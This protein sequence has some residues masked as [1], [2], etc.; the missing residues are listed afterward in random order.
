MSNLKPLA[1]QLYSLRDALQADFEGI[2][3]SVAAMGYV[4]VEPYAGMPCAASEAAALF[5]ELSLEVCNSH[6]PFPD[7]ANLDAVLADA[8][9]Y[10]LA[11]VAVAYLP[12]SEFAS[13]DA[14]KRTCERLNRASET[15]QK[16]ALQ[17]GYHNH[18]WEYKVLDGQATLDVML[19][20]LADEVFLEIDTY[21]AQVGGLDAVDVVKQAGA[22]APL[23]HLKDGSL[24]LEDNMTAVGAGKMDLPGI[25]A[26]TERTAD[27]HI[28]EI[29]R[30]DGDMLQAVH[31]SYR[32]LTSNQLA[33]GNV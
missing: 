30:C 7:A 21:W 1:L 20:E 23:I 15:L 17:L 4:G 8:E 19:A 2:L 28:V 10:G 16:S 24:R 33:R 26:A 6:V 32:Y 27:W 29:D 25:V 14:V 11:R 5:Q 18:W 22:R 31:D 13:L 9:A 3:R 12:D